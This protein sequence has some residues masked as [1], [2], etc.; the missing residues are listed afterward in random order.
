MLLEPLLSPNWT[1]G[2]S[3]NWVPLSHHVLLRHV[4]FERLVPPVP[5]S[6]TKGSPSACISTLFSNSSEAVVP[7][8]SASELQPVVGPV[9]L[10]QPQWWK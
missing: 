3:P 9:G 5:R 7:A 8:C 2:L 1:S 10:N 6:P 4:A